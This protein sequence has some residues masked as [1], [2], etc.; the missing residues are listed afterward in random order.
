MAA[1]TSDNAVGNDDEQYKTDDSGHYA[2]DRKRSGIDSGG[3]KM[4]AINRP[5][6]V[7][8]IH[9]ELSIWCEAIERQFN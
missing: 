1:T 4:T 9:I 3:F 6:M 5:E 2:A 7:S 8:P